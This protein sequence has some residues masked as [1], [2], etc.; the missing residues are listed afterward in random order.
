MLEMAEPI[1]NE[2]V[3]PEREGTEVDDAYLQRNVLVVAPVLCAIC[4]KGFRGSESHERSLH[5]A[6]PNMQC[7]KPAFKHTQFI[8]L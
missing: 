5:K 6:L 4:D 8:V 1:T 7:K 3:H 2:L